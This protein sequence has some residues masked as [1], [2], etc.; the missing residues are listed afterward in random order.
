MEKLM[1]T[2]DVNVDM[3]PYTDLLVSVLHF[4]NFTDEQLQNEIDHAKKCFCKLFTMADLGNDYDDEWNVLKRF[5]VEFFVSMKDYMRE[6][7]EKM[8]LERTEDLIEYSGNAHLKPVPHLG[9]FELY[10]FVE[11]PIMDT[12]KYSEDYLK[13]TSESL[14]EMV[15]PQ[16]N[17]VLATLFMNLEMDPNGFAYCPECGNIRYS[18]SAK[19]LD[20]CFSCC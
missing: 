4:V 10:F 11:G 7:I 13:L 18:Y 17:C 8:I 19:D 16:I 1:Y 6:L 2:K 14:V 12:W 15:K 9:K 3:A 5:P 20:T